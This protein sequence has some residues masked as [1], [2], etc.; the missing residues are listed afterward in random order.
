M[1]NNCK[2]LTAV[3]L[4]VLGWSLAACGLL[5]ER[6]LMGQWESVAAPQRTLDLFS[7]HTYSLRLSG[8]TLGF[9]TSLLGPERGSW[10]VEANELVLSGAEPSGAK[11]EVRWPIN[12]MSGDEVV[13]AGERWR[14]VGRASAAP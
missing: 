1:P 13:L 6:R 11:R 3:V 8:K 4:V 14:R 9:L 5:R 12:E 10:R 2:T 7:D